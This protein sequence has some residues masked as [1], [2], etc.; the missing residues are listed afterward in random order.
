MRL[1]KSAI[2]AAA[3]LALLAC[4]MAATT[5]ARPNPAGEWMGQPFVLHCA[6]F[7]SVQ[8]NQAKAACC[9]L[10]WAAHLLT[11]HLTLSVHTLPCLPVGIA[12]PRSAHEISKP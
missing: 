8:K 10:R 3:L 12:P 4:L 7:A 5:Q 6:S 11:L 9:S 2:A 1:S